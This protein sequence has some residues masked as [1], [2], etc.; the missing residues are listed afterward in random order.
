VLDLSIVPVN[1]VDSLFTLLSSNIDRAIFKS[2]TA[3][4]ISVFG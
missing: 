1:S 4:E 2:Y 3:F